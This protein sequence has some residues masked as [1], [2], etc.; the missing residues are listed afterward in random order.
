M[1]KDTALAQTTSDPPPAPQPKSLT[2][3]FLKMSAWTTVHM[4]VEL[5]VR[6]GGNLI[7]TRL[8]VPEVFGLM[9]FA[10]SVQTGAQLLTDIGVERSVVREKDGESDY[11][12]RAAWTVRLVRSAFVASIMLI[13]ALIALPIAGLY[14]SPDSVMAA[15]ETKW[16]VAIMA[17]TPLLKAFGSI[18]EALAQRR[19]QLN[20]LVPL[21]VGMQLTNLGLMI[22]AVMIW[23]T[24]WTMAGVLVTSTLIRAAL[25]YFVLP[26]P[27]MAF[28][29]DVEIARRL[30]DFGKW[31]IGSSVFGFLSNYAERLIFASMLDL[32]LFALYSIARLWAEAGQRIL[33]FVINSAGMSALSEVIRTPGRDVVR[34]FGRIQMVVDG[35]VVIGFLGFYLL[36]GP[37]VEFLYNEDFS[38]ASAFAPLLALI[39]LR[40]RFVPFETLLLSAGK[41]PVLMYAT[42]Q[43][44]AAAWVFT[45]VAFQY[46]GFETAI[47]AYC[48][49]GLVSVP[50]ILISARPLLPTRN[51]ALDWAWI[52]GSVGLGAFVAMGQ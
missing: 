21:E 48:L 52:V 34:P 46:S 43:H 23:P 17:L 49:S 33:T 28:I 1:T 20:R 35:L 22:P 11:F 26:G 2:Q 51:F 16:V 4:G 14:A 10:L 50:Y 5:V 32:R 19:L 9:A 24:V 29:W 41:T 18:N 36:I 27:S 47:I 37:F 7:L 15:P 12:L 25:T 38:A 40:L 13:V 39:V 42:M 31:L 6:L 44:A 30:W 45:W 3:R 8:L